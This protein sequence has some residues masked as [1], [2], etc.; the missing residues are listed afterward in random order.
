MIDLVFQ[1]YNEEFLIQ[2][3]NV[4]ESDANTLNQKL[5]LA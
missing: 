5:L 1:T 4:N 2:V 3:D